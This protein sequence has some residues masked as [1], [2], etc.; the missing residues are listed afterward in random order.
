M[1]SLRGV[2]KRYATP[3]LADIDL[4]L[5]PGEVH[6]LIGANGAGKSTLAKI[7]S[8]LIRASSGEMTLEGSH[9]APTDKTEAEN[10]G[11]HIVQQ[12]LNLI[13]PLSVAENLFLNRLPRHHGFVDFR[14][15]NEQA[16]AALDLVDLADID[17][18][19]PVEQLG[20]GHRQLVEI[21]SALSR[22][23]RW[24]LL[25]E[26]T[27]ALTT[28]QIERLFEHVRRLSSSGVGLIYISHRME[29]IQQ[30]CDRATVLRDGRLMA[31]RKVSELPL[32]EAVRLMV[33]DTI[34]EAAKRDRAVGEP[35]LRVEHL[36]REPL[37]RD[38]TFTAHRGEVL[39]IAG[40]VGSGRTELLRAIFGADAPESGALYVGGSDR[41]Q[42][43][44]SPA[45]AVRAGLAMTPEDRQH[46]GLLLSKSVR[47]NMTLGRLP[48]KHGWI[49]HAA[50][51]QAAQAYADQTDIRCR[52]I[53][54]PVDEL[55]GGNQ[56]KALISRWLMHDADAY[57]FDEP[58]RGVD[59]AAKA[60]IHGLMHELAANNKGVVVVSSDLVE[61]MSICDRIVVM[62][63]GRLVTSLDRGEWSEDQILAAALG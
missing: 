21:A 42:L 54:Q 7:I 11:V 26:P 63:R 22:D 20:V 62:A 56:Q 45:Q 53:E 12:E 15:L 9:Y 33:G 34:Q 37:V 1:L 32:E 35:A 6:A 10:R 4:E 16:E 23:C 13:E 60:T 46:E 59:V 3:V 57:L 2:G 27:A 47:L 25:D 51:R 41:P 24:L 40:L 19:T 38:I 5:Q 14:A 8:G 52:S 28:P 43:F 55:S 61:L 50:E 36:G 49:D 29:E 44:Q 58:T 30:I 39:G 18:R 17:P 31:T 48:S